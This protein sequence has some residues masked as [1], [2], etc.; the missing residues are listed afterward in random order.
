VARSSSGA[1]RAGGGSG[2]CLSS[3]DGGSKDDGLSIW[4]RGAAADLRTACSPPVV[5]STTQGMTSSPTVVRSIVVSL[6][7][8]LSLLH[9]LSFVLSLSLKFGDLGNGGGGADDASSSTPIV[10]WPPHPPLRHTLR[11]PHPSGLRLF[12]VVSSSRGGAV[13]VQ[14]RG[15]EG[16]GGEPRRPACGGCGARP[17]GATCLS[18]GGHHAC[19]FI[20]FI[21]LNKVCQETWSTHGRR[22]PWGWWAALDKGLF[23]GRMVPSALYRVKRVPCLVLLAL[24]KLAVSVVFLSLV[25]SHVLICDQSESV[26]RQF[27]A[28]ELPW[29]IC[30][31]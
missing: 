5:R 30:M 7:I 19:L 24:G 26:Y 21:T 13:E 1:R 9:S 31:K 17:V 14:E 11:S 27:Q 28:Q 4:H 16:S 15:W 25:V 12:L 6:S 20:F 10:R 3:H 29:V 18:G 8:S 2:T 22:V 23:V